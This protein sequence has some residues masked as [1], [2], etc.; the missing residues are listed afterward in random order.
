MACLIETCPGGRRQKIGLIHALPHDP[1]LPVLDARGSIP[2]RRSSC[3]GSASTATMFELIARLR[4]LERRCHFIPR[5]LW[6]DSDLVS[7]AEQALE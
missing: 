4:D 6:I 5:G 3:Q 1:E 2:G 7:S